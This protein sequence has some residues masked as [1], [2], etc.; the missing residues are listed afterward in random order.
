MPP[1]LFPQN[2]KTREDLLADLNTL[3][4]Q[5]RDW[6]QGRMFSLVFHAGEDIAS[7]AQ[8]A[9]TM[10]LMA[11]GLSPFAFPS[12]FKM[13]TEVVAMLADLFHGQEDTVGHMTSGGSES[14][15]LAVKAARD[16]AR[17]MKPHITRPELLMPLSAHPAFNKAAHYLGLETVIVPTQKETLAADV[18]AMRRAVTE[19]TILVV[20][21][22]PSYPHGIIDPIEE[23]ARMAAD[24]D[25]WMHVDACV[26]GLE[27]PFIK[28]LGYPVPNFDFQIPGVCSLSADIHK[29]GFT[30]KGA[31]VVLYRNPELRKYQLFA[32]ADW[33]GGL[34]G[35]PNVSGSR[36]GGPI[37]ASWALCKYLGREGYRDLA[38][39]SMKA[40]QGVIK[41]IEAIPELYVLG[42]PA[43]TV[44]AIASDVINILA[45]GE[46]MK[47][48]GWYLD[49]Q[50][51]PPS[52]HLTVSPVHEMV[53]EAFLADLR[54]AVS[55]IPRFTAEESAANEAAMY[56][57]GGA[58]SDGAV[59]GEFIVQYLNDLY[60]VPD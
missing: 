50:Q 1:V 31:S 44:F 46:K 9:S 21:S 57:R 28:G 41:G 48:Y 49:G 51:L 58:F 23:L 30:P 16:Y 39:R 25:I 36:P 24:R 38:G 15:L 56:G 34:Y 35:T 3:K 37:A 33:P 6:K 22:A 59:T 60:R 2:G 45:L 40:T 7:V 32:Y 17:A 27:L 8:E 12:L 18:E 5:D 11:N 53:V 29:Y 47:E 13:E 19:N 10:F 20:G 26:G 42:K 14:I 55:E 52:L 4:S 43:A 54:Q